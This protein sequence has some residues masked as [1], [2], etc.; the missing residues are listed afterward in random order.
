MTSAAPKGR[1]EKKTA[2]AFRISFIT[3]RT[4]GGLTRKSSDHREASILSWKRLNERVIKLDF[5]TASKRCQLKTA[6]SARPREL[7]E[8]EMVFRGG[9][10]DHFG[11]DDVALEKLFGQRV[12]NV[13]LYG[14]PKRSGAIQR[15]KSFT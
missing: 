12:F 9:D 14:A 5:M 3:P 6:R 10:F 11:L 1:H 13:T 7:A 2:I 4:I 8:L 15:I